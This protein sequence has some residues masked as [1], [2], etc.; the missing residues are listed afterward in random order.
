MSLGLYVDI[1]VFTLSSAAVYVFVGG[2]IEISLIDWLIDDD[3]DD[4]DDDDNNN[5]NNSSSSSNNNNNKNINKFVLT[6]QS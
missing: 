6:K 4:N 5:N 1:Y 3:D 2:A